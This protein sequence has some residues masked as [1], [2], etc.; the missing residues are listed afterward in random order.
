MQLAPSLVIDQIG[1]DL[2][3]L[4]KNIAEA[5]QWQRPVFFS[6]LDIKDGFWR[7]NAQNGKEFAFA[8]VLPSEDKSPQLVVPMMY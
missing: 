1:H 3:R 8:Y 6:K 5:E 7:L 2:M 4:T